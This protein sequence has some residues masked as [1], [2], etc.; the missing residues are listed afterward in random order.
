MVE[1][2]AGAGPGVDGPQRLA[3]L[4]D[5]A[6]PDAARAAL[7]GWWPPF[8][9]HRVLA[10]NPETLQS[11]I[12]FGTH[13]LRANTLGERLRELVILRIA[14][15]A[16]CSYEWGQHAGLSERLGIPEADIAR[17]TEGPEVA[18][19]TPLERALL[20]GV[21]QLMS[22]NRVSDEVYAV[23]A[24]QLSPAQLIDYAFLIGEFVLVAYALN[25]F[26]IQPDPGL[27]PLPVGPAR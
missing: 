7:G 16:R 13:I 19:W 26:R 8:N 3:G 4:S 24:E 20:A 22:T 5:E 23:L 10:H 17:V 18:G 6:M 2:D 12:G 11:W 9:I 1:L 15:N 25:L 14:W 21:D 27:R